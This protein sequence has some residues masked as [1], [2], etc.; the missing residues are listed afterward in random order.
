MKMS[1]LKT[2]AMWLL[3][4]EGKDRDK[5]FLFCLFVLSFFVCSYIQILAIHATCSKN[6]KKKEEAVRKKTENKTT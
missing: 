5:I 2:R 6:T 3:K 1:H 4:K